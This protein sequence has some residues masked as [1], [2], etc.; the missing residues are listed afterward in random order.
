MDILKDLR[1]ILLR[2]LSVFIPEIGRQ[3]RRVALDHGLHDRSHRLHIITVQIQLHHGIQIVHG[4]VRCVELIVD[5]IELLRGEGMRDLHRAG[6]FLLRTLPVVVCMHLFI[7]FRD[8]LRRAAAEHFTRV[9]PRKTALYD[10]FDGCEGISSHL[11]EI[12][13]NSR[14]VDLQDFLKCPAELLLRLICGRNIIRPEIADIRLRKCQTVH[15]AVGLERDLIHLDI[16]RRNHIVG[17]TSH[18]VI[19]KFFLIKFDIF[20]IICTQETLIVIFK[21]PCGSP[22]DSQGLPDCSFDLSRLDPVP[23]DLDHIAASSQQDIVSVGI[24][25]CKVAGVIKTVREG[26]LRFLR[27]I[28]VPADIRILKAELSRLSVRHFI[29]VLIQKPDLRA[30]LRFSDRAGLISLIDDKYSDGKAALTGCIDID[31]LNVLVIDIVGGLASHDQHAEERSRLVSKLSDV[32]RCEERDSD[33]LLEEE[34]HEH[35]R[36]LDHRVG[37]DI[38]PAAGNAQALQDNNNGRHKVQRRKQSEPVL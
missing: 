2:E 4:R 25:P 13:M 18:E 16:V 7:Q 12:I 31:Q 9:Q 33:P 35:H 24:L 21:S 36:V 17:Q 28:N 37:N 15:L 38:I 5:H 20:L 27:K 3:K 1:S 14:T 23:V 10:Q 11:I 8:L 6:I 19:P 26:F 34:L 32:G 30:D 22:L 29:S